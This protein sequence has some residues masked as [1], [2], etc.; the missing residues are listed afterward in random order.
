MPLAAPTCTDG[1]LYGT[2]AYLQW[3]PE[4]PAPPGLTAQGSVLAWQQDGGPWTELPLIPAPVTR[5]AHGPL[6]APGMYHW[7][8]K[9]RYLS[10]ETVVD[11][12]YYAAGTPLPCL[13]VSAPPPQPTAL[14]ISAQPTCGETCVALRWNATTQDALFDLERWTEDPGQAPATAQVKGSAAN[15]N[16]VKA[17]GYYCYHIAANGSGVWSA[18]DCVT[19]SK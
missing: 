8:V 19:I 13:Q 18:K 5:Y 3:I 10:G 16:D 11:S 9:G 17:G 1:N 6:T 15:D 14:K 7:Q 4:A 2:T 12:P